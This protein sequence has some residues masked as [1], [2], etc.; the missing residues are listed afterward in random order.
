MLA[1]V[2]RTQIY[3]DEAQAKELA[4]RAASRRVT[5]SELIREAL[6][7]Y[8]GLGNGETE[9]LR[10]FREAVDAAAGIAPYLPDGATYVS[11]LRAA[12]VRRQEQLEERWRG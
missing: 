4:R 1:G 3:L 11:E 7:A 5:K 9:R 2:K 8:L 10:R 6:D 12:D